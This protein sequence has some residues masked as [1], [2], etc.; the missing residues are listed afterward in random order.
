MPAPRRP[1]QE[2]SVA[3][4]AKIL[5]AACGSLIDRGYGAT[6]VGEVQNRA[7]VARGTLLHHFPT[8]GALMAGVVEDIIERRLRVLTSVETDGGDDDNA[9]GNAGNDGNDDNAAGNDDNDADTPPAI[10]PIPPRAG[11]TSWTS[12]GRSCRFLRSPR[13]SSSGSHHGRIPTCGRR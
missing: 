7:G 2:R 4:R 13:R 10:A 3:T 8:R 12:S 11:T 9:A 6:T 5:E 1:K